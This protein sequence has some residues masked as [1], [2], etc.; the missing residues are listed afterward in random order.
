MTSRKFCFGRFSVLKR[1]DTSVKYDLCVI[2]QHVDQLGRDHIDV[3]R[4]A[5]A[6]GATMIQLRDKELSS[7]ALFEVAQ[8]IRT[9]T[10]DYGAAFIVNDRVD[11]ALAAQADGVHV[12]DSD[13]PVSSARSLLGPGKEVGASV[14]T[15][16][17]AKA[18]EAAGATYLGVGPIYATGSKPDAGAAIG[19]DPI[20]RLKR[21]VAIPLLAIGGLTCD[22]VEAVV[23]A[24]A[25][26]VAV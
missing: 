13:L 21:A 2:T 18:A 12:G 17:A 14:D 16:E 26:G 9:L 19:L 25:D 10:R 5:L 23:R 20:P 3:A 6:G 7:R 24:G 8:Q 22:N 4:T 1:L 11:I 15:A